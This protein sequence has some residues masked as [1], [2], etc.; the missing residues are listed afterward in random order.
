MAKKAAAKKPRKRP[1]KR[2]RKSVVEYT[3]KR[4]NTIRALIQRI[5]IA[6]DELRTV[7][8]DYEELIQSCGDAESLLVDSI[9]EL[10]R[11]V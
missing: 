7:L 11:F 9:D 6:R 3:E 5:G 1:A 4:S 8:D 10:S 2:K